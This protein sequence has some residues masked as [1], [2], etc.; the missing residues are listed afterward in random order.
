MLETRV[1]T[2]CSRGSDRKERTLIRSVSGIV[3]ISGC[4]SK[5]VTR[6]TSEEGA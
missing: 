2:L 1:S 4:F 5:R 3:I 6:V